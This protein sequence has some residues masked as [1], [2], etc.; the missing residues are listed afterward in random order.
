MI[1]GE[2]QGT[3]DKVREVYLPTRCGGKCVD[4]RE[5]PGESVEVPTL[6]WYGHTSARVCVKIVRGVGGCR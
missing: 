4:V 5:D 2:R 3:R 1:A 6:V